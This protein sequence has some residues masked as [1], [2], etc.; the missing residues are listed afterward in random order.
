MFFLVVLIGVEVSWFIHEGLSFRFVRVTTGGL[1]GFLVLSGLSL[2]LFNVLPWGGAN[3]KV[4]LG[5]NF[6]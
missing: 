4:G 2:A 3:A 1:E 6:V 5:G